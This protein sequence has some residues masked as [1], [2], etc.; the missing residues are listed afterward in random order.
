MSSFQ[1]QSESQSVLQLRYP[2]NTIGVTSTAGNYLYNLTEKNEKILLEL[3]QW[4]Q[5]EKNNI[6]MLYNQN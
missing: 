5:D 1:S 4:C 2:P 6:N 3:L